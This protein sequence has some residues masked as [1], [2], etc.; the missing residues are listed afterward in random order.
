MG[1]A[2]TQDIQWGT[3]KPVRWLMRQFIAAFFVYSLLV[4]LSE[5]EAFAQSHLGLNVEEQVSSVDQVLSPLLEEVKLLGNEIQTPLFSPLL[6]KRELFAGK[7]SFIEESFKTTETKLRVNQGVIELSSPV[8]E[9]LFFQYSAPA[10][11]EIALASLQKTEEESLLPVIGTRNMER[12]ATSSQGAFVKEGLSIGHSSRLLNLQQE[13][14]KRGGE[15]SSPRN[16]A[17]TTDQKNLSD[18]RIST[19]FDNTSSSLLRAEAFTP[20]GNLKFKM[21]PPLLQWAE[22][23][24]YVIKEDSFSQPPEENA[25]NL[26]E[27]SHLEQML[28]LKD[29][30]NI[31]SV[32]GMKSD[33]GEPILQS[34]MQ[35][36]DTFWG[37]LGKISSAEVEWRETLGFQSWSFLDTNEVLTARNL[38]IKEGIY[39]LSQD[40]LRDLHALQSIE[41]NEEAT[42]IVDVEQF[43]KSY[44][45]SDLN[46]Q[47]ISDVTPSLNI[48]SQG[49]YSLP[50]AI[51]SE[52]R[53]VI[54]GGDRLLL[55]E[56][57]ASDE[58][59]LNN[60]DLLLNHY[61]LESKK[62]ILSSGG[63]LYALV[64]SHLAG[65][66]INS[67][68][69]YLKSQARREVFENQFSAEDFGT[70]TL[71]G[72]Y[73]GNKGSIIY[74]GVGVEKNAT[75]AEVLHH[76]KLHIKG[77]LEQIGHEELED[78]T[79]RNQSEVS[80]ENL[81]ALLSGDLLYEQGG[82]E[83]I[84]V[85]QAQETDAGYFTLN[86]GAGYTYG[87]YLY[88]F[89]HEQSKKGHWVLAAV[90]T[91][92]KTGSTEGEHLTHARII[93]PSTGV[94]LANL[95][96]ANRL[97]DHT[98][99]DRRYFAKKSALWGHI[100]GDFGRF[101]DSSAQ[102]KTDF[103]YQLIQLGG[104]LYRGSLGDLSMRAGVMAGYGFSESK[105]RNPYLSGLHYQAKGRGNAYA[106][107]AY[108]TLG[109]FEES[110][111]DLS[112]QYLQHDSRVKR[113]DQPQDER[114]HANG[115]I[116]ILEAGRVLDFTESFM[117]QPHFRA[118]WRDVFQKHYQA[119]DGT[120]I[121]AN[122]GYFEWQIGMRL[123]G[124]SAEASPYFNRLVPYGELN[125]GQGTKDYIVR[126]NEYD[127]A[128]NG[129]HNMVEVKL[130]FKGE[131]S[132]QQLLWGEISHLKGRN[133]YR[134][135]RV[136][137]GIAWAI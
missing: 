119:D 10:L 79:A 68:A 17:V 50:T 2:I 22:S 120:N 55:S 85:E 18:Q 64:D 51:Q 43:R 20:M 39:S 131:R 48:S 31:R 41:V 15:S 54:T 132:N 67:G 113:T 61:G 63:N 107:G 93:H 95:V 59:W 125:Y 98:L 91:G 84:Y 40:E 77:V 7:L 124:T 89:D 99:K 105:T 96:A 71:Q 42:L 11:I 73:R 9:R 118:T 6:D 102:S 19:H 112:L 134:D 1:F 12:L 4:F 115:W 36:M 116:A 136:K 37:E 86:R 62:T 26:Q 3:L 82:I 129:P 103:N 133:H 33:F 122:R 121:Q 52:G 44:K 5:S 14:A 97:F 92:S 72:D 108:V 27:L 76:D 75:G 117:L 57:Y 74:F 114:Y 123:I 60:A 49:Y 80:I 109:T 70:L 126:F 53:V 65:D 35:G 78:F 8:E 47:L 87:P 46:A 81:H 104:D 34:E 66:L 128:F 69:V 28:A 56:D 29:V 94:Y 106:L 101:R 23:S 110:Y 45:G 83:L 58:T 32:A 88:D 100:N 24:H 13:W 38:Q 111:L 25:F 90:T 16:V 30:D 130:G 21:N 127:L 135:S 137:L